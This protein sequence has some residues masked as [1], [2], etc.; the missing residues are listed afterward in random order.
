MH[1]LMI[2][3]VDYLDESSYIHAVDDSDFYFVL[4]ASCFSSSAYLTLS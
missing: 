2:I 4:L 3:C 1:L